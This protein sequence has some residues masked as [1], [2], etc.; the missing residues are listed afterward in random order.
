M[1]SSVTKVDTVSGRLGSAG[2]QPLLRSASA[3]KT[4]FLFIAS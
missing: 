2:W 4:K 1:G 3:A